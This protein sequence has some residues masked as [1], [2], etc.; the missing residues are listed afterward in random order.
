M[1]NSLPDNLLYL[2]FISLIIY[3]NVFGVEL[4]FNNIVFEINLLG[5][6]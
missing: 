1:L 5:Y 2:D 4:E 6:I 3:I